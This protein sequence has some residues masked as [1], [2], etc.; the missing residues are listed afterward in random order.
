[1][2]HS[3][4]TVRH[5]VLAISSLYEGFDP[6]RADEPRTDRFA[7]SHYNKAIS[8]LANDSEPN[9]NNV[10]VVCVLFVCIELLRGNREAAISHAS[11]GVHLLNT[12]GHNLRLA[13]IFSQIG[14]FPPFF[15][16]EGV[17]FPLLLRNTGTDE[18]N[19]VFFST[20]EA[21]LALDDLC[22]RTLRLI[23]AGNPYRLDEVQGAPPQDLYDWQSRA[24]ADLEAWDKAFA[25]FQATRLAPNKHDTTSLALK[26]RE[27][28]TKIWLANCFTRGE[29]GY[30]ES[31]DDFAE[32]VGWARA[33]ADKLDAIKMTPAKFTFDTGFNPLMHFIVHRCR[34]LRIRLE[35]LDLMQRLSSQRESMWDASLMYDMSRRIVEVEHDIDLD[36]DYD[37]ND[38]TVPPDLKRPNEECLLRLSASC[39]YEPQPQSLT[40]KFSL[41]EGA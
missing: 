25:N 9:M 5:A 33:A 40:A 38:E 30:D 39:D 23:R 20:S 26:I 21:Q 10:L 19:P 6:V 14:I 3:E 13:T 8:L 36:G 16:K 37:L 41:G 1:M 24:M 34:I 31:K 29:I 27:R 17:D 32:L 22:I 28:L 11:H 35:A 15:V 2:T 18:S 12:L 4:P 7:V